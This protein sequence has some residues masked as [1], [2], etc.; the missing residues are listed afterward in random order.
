MSLDLVSLKEALRIDTADEDDNLQR[1]L[2]S[3]T[4]E[5]LRF[6]GLMD[7]PT[8]STDGYG[9]SSSTSTED[10]TPMPDVVNAIFLLVQADRDGDPQKREDYTRGAFALM[11]PYRISLGMA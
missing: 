5:A 7:V 4:Q 1:L 3:A 11:R 10:T 9:D 8:M 2:D 6:M